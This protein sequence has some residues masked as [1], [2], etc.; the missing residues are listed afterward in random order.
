M[1]LD[2]V[3]DMD[4]GDVVKEGLAGTT[5]ERLQER[6]IAYVADISGMPGMVARL[7]A[8]PSMRKRPYP[9]VLDRDGEPT[10]RL[11][12][13]EGHVT[14]LRLDALEILSIA[15]VKDPAAI[16]TLVAAGE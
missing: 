15:Y 8:L 1:E 3:G 9:M 4:A 13:R 14:L 16:S 6:A 5:G 12:A 11:P 10:A 2:A 7:F